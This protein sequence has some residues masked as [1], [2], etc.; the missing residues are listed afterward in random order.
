MQT[1]RQDPSVQAMQANTNAL[2]DAGHTAVVAA[3]GAT[4][5]NAT[6]IGENVGVVL[7]TVT[8]SSQGVRLAPGYG[9]VGKEV[10]VMAASAKG[11]KVYPYSGERLYG[12]ATNAA[13]ALVLNKSSRF[14][15]VGDGTWR[16]HK[17][18]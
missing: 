4:Q 9:K 14:I 17:G 18:A 11:V 13:V 1:L 3:A 6:Q 7:V 10:L 2:Y 5:G 12:A 15:S 8:A 16:I